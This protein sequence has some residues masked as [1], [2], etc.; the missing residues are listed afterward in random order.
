MNPFHYVNRQANIVQQ[1]PRL[2]ASSS[3]NIEPEMPMDFD[4]L[5]LLLF[6]EKVDTV[7]IVTCLR[8]LFKSCLR[9][10]SCNMYH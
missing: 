9:P 5:F 4:Y 3:K 7:I 1:P 6:G 2:I 8:S 10:H